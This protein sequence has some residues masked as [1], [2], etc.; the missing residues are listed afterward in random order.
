MRTVV[1]CR[2]ALGLL[3]LAFLSPAFAGDPPAP[4]PDADEQAQVALLG[5]GLE[6]LKQRRPADAIATSFDRIIARFGEKFGT[7]TRKIYSARTMQESLFYMLQA[8]NAKQA[9]V[10]VSPVWSQAHYFK[11]YALVELGRLP[12]ARASLERALA[13]SPMNAQY[14]EELGDLSLREKN[15][16]AALEKFQ[17]AE[18]GARVYAPDATKNAEL[19]RAWRGVGYVLVEQ[20]KLDEAEALYRKC[21]ELDKNDQRAAAELKYVLN[22]KAKN[23][24]APK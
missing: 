22:A 1:H 21:L 19:A 18:E 24:G 12:E 2:L 4:R 15:L 23:A 9:A 3:V 20:G 13:M 11:G 5:S 6:L 8:A 17:L 14:L 16:A 7:D 10:V